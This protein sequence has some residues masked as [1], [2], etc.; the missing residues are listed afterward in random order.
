MEQSS[1]K[2]TAR[3]KAAMSKKRYAQLK[4]EFE[5]VLKNMEPNQPYSQV[6]DALMKTICDVLEYDS[7]ANTYIK[8]EKTYTQS[9][10]NYYERNKERLNSQRAARYIAAKSKIEN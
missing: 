10:K 2:N 8:K 5:L 4:T 9:Q 6:L 7:N 1:S 3:P